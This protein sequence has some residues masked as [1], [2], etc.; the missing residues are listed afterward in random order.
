MILPSDNVGAM[1]H[2]CEERRGVYR[3]TEYIG[4]SRV[5]LVYELPLA[6]VIYDFYDRLKARRA[7]TARWI[8]TCSAS[9]PARWSSSIFSSTAI[10]S[11]R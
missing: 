9:A 3:K 8:M 11:M 7:D 6:E 1:M 2:L 5:I 4:K 10:A